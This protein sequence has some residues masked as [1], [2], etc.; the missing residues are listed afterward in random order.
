MDRA[1]QM[2]VNKQAW[3]QSDRV[4]QRAS[5][6]GKARSRPRH[7]IGYQLPYESD[8]IGRQ[9]CGYARWEGRVT[10]YVNQIGWAVRIRTQNDKN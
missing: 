10:F 7:L 9:E 6:D 3:M 2:A 4:R 8:V 1:E 5:I